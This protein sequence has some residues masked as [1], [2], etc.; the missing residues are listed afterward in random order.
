MIKISVIRSLHVLTKQQLFK[1]SFVLKMRVTS[2]TWA[3]KLGS[4]LLA[5]KECRL[6]VIQIRWFGRQAAHLCVFW[7]DC[8]ASQLLKFF[9]CALETASILHQSLACVFI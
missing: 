6:L 8:L 3:Y 9:D 7:K 1:A 2:D 4:S 5:E